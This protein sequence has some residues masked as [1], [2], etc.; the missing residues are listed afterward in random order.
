MI[1]LVYFSIY[2]RSSFILIFA[3]GSKYSTPSKLKTK[4]TRKHESFF[5]HWFKKRR[6]KP[7][8]EFQKNLNSSYSKENI[9][10]SFFFFGSCCIFPLWSVKCRIRWLFLSWT[11]ENVSACIPRC[12]L[13]RDYQLTIHPLISNARLQSVLYCISFTSFFRYLLSY[14]PITEAS[15]SHR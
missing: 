15:H 7:L 12:S 8:S 11:F 14:L 6:S 10:K 13:V 4:M 2:T 9:W 3:F 1:P 5:Y